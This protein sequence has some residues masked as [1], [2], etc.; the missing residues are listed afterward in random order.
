MHLRGKVDTTVRVISGLG[1]AFDIFPC[2][3]DPTLRIPEFPVTAPL[4]WPLPKF[5]EIDS[6][7]STSTSSND[8]QKVI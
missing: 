2:G 5:S 1:G 8:T 6:I 3:S 4:H 7:L